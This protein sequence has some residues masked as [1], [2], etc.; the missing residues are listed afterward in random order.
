MEEI[1]DN[2]IFDNYSLSIIKNEFNNPNFSVINNGT[3]FVGKSDKKSQ[4]FDTIYLG[5]R[6][7]TSLFIPAYIKEIKPSAF[8]AHSKLQSIEF[9]PNSSIEIIGKCSF[10]STR[11]KRIRIPSSVKIIGKIAFNFSYLKIIEFEEDSQLTNIC[12]GAFSNLSSV[13]KILIPKNVKTIEE[14]AF[15]CCVNLKIIEFQKDSNLT[16]IG[17][18]AFLNCGIKSICFPA[19]FAHF[20]SNILNE[21]INLISVEFL[22]E[23]LLINDFDSFD[24]V[25]IISMPNASSVIFLNSLDQSHN[26]IL[27]ISPGAKVFQK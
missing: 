3:L 19:S 2:W 16:L 24:E 8:Y 22:G 23:E 4:I 25:K 27:L 11:I 9:A 6:D 21:C 17:K 5:C 10:Y 20:Y 1:D 15:S 26:F 14:N 18:C 13:E 7:I 12:M